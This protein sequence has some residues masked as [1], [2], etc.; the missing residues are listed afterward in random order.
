MGET[1][2]V[3]ISARSVTAPRAVS[4]F[5]LVEIAIVLVAVALLLGAVLI[6]QELMTGA[7]VRAIIQQQDGIKAAYLGFV[8]RYRQPPGDYSGATTNIPGVSTAAC[9]VAGSFG[10]GNGDARIDIANGEHIL[11]WEHLSKSGFLTGAYTCTGNAAV[12]PDTVPRN[13]YGHYLRLAYDNVYADGAPQD[14][15]NLK[16]GNGINSDLL[17]EVDLK[18]DDANALRGSFRGS[19]YTSGTA[20]DTGCWDATSGLWG[21]QPT[22]ANCGGASLF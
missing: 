16:T 3:V 10:N 11:A 20:T 12:D 19:T 22:R 8:D 5:T 17:R 4:G 2:R 6:G 9:G 15:N 18:T 1:D 21:G 7:R 13:A 14:R